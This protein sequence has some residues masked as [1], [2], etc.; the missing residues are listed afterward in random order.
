VRA[1]VQRLEESAA[2][3][4]AEIA[5]R[6]ED[7]GAVE[8][9]LASVGQTLGRTSGRAALEGGTGPNT[10]SVQVALS[11]PEDREITAA[12]FSRRWRERTGAIPGIEELTFSASLFS[13]GDPID[14]E[15]RGTDV[16]ALQQVARD[17]SRQLE[18]FPG[19][20]DVRDSYRAANDELELRLRPEAEGLG[21]S[22]ADLARQVRQAFYGD[23]AQRLA[24]GGEDV[25]VMVRYPRDERRALGD[26]ESLRIRT[27]LGDA[28]PLSVVADVR[29]GEGPAAIRRADGARVVNVR[30]DVDLGV[31]SAQEVLAGLEADVLP[32][33]LRGAPSV[34]YGLEGEQREQRESLAGLGRGFLFAL[35][36]IF[37][38]L[39]VPLRSYSQPLLVMSTI[40]L[41]AVGAVAGHALLG[42]P[43]SFSS[44]IGMVALS[45]VVVNDS[46]VLVDWVNRGRRAGLD[47]RAA[48]LEA[49]QS[50]FRPV[51]LTSLTTCLGLTPLL[52]EKSVQAQFLIPMAV[53]ISAGVVAATV[54]SLLVVPAACLTLDDLVHGLARRFS[55]SRPSG[56]GA[57]DALPQ[58]AAR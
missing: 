29:M 49:G 17:L 55:G 33:L 3:V 36:A 22:V 21:L 31:T 50:R 27:P 39:A 12:E 38:L 40:P 56:A 23:E 26:V 19:V 8:H 13:A 5:T 11:A 18:R 53:S 43:L 48:V 6:P 9:V 25:K 58:S 34:Q 42:L 41:G 46:L 30:A 45:G 10:G 57:E 32:G 28:V 44:V 47:I 37:T 15:L 2:A 7:A 4:R 20:R 14:I 54:I 51:F 24:R 52:L 1:V 16:V 35:L